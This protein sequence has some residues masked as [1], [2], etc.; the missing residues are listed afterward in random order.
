MSR[1]ASA[2]ACEAGAAALI[3]RRP[4]ETG[5]ARFQLPDGQVLS[6]RVTAIVRRSAA[7]TAPQFREGLKVSEWE[8]ALVSLVVQAR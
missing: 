5:K 8:T 7:H 3:G 6:V 4:V 2:I 1:V